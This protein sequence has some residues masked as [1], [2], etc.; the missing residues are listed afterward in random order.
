MIY[1]KII[2][3][4]LFS[5]DAETTH[6]V[7]IN[8]GNKLSKYNLIKKVIKNI[9][10]YE[11]DKL[12][13]RL[14]NINFKNPV[15]LAAGFDKNAL[16]T[17]FIPS[18][19]FGHMEIGSITGEK[20]FGNPKP[21]LFRLPKDKA[22]MVH[23]GLKNDGAEIIS[24]RLKHKK[25]LIPVGISIAKTND[26]NIL[27]KD[28]IKDYCKS[29]RLFAKIGAYTTLNIS[30]PNSKDG[31]TFCQD[32]IA[33]GKLL[34]EI[35]KIKTAKPTLLKISPDIDKEQLSRII[36]LSRKYDIRGL[37]I[38]NLSKKRG[39]LKTDKTILN[40]YSGGISGLPMKSISN[41]LIKETYKLSKGK[42]PIIGCGGIFNANDAYEKIKL[43]SSLLQLITGMIYRGPAIVK[44]INKG[45]VKL[46]EEDKFENIKE[47]IGYKN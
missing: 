33:L 30:C 15:G 25:F 10:Y 45:L 19:G 12:N 27:G 3:P 16:L 41:L 36:K 9:Y 37:I 42:I 40:K 26:K 4:V 29:F 28:A 20:C 32:T 7:T 23:Y 39:N 46:I 2:R 14:F 13:L 1:E 17:Q 47:A 11:N 43:G 6:D 31:T 35:N 18:F 22:I 24:K 8:L 34:K 38:S 44:D 21:R 5:I